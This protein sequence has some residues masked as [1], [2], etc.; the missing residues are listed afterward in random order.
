[1]TNA[2]I[3]HGTFAS[4]YYVLIRNTLCPPLIYIRRNRDTSFTI[5]IIYKEQWATIVV[6]KINNDTIRKT[7]RRVSTRINDNHQVFPVAPFHRPAI[8]HML[9]FKRIYDPLKKNMRIKTILLIIC[10]IFNFPS[11]LRIGMYNILS[12]FSSVERCTKKP[13]YL[14]N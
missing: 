13:F 6:S 12:Q 10:S 1:M 4:L 9:F 8:C 14:L 2:Q 11:V 3:N 5:L 7:R